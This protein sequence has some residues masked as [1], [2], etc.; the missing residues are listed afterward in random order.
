MFKYLYWDKKAPFLLSSPPFLPQASPLLLLADSGINGEA[1]GGAACGGHLAGNF[2][3]GGPTSHWTCSP[4]RTCAMRFSDLQPAVVRVGWVSPVEPEHEV[5]P[6]LPLGFESPRRR[7]AA[8]WSAAWSRAARMEE[9]GHRQT[10][11]A[12][13]RHQRARGGEGDRGEAPQRGGWWPQ[14]SRSD[15]VSSSDTNN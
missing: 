5:V 10:E 1:A 2:L 14:E 4:E 13:S 3:W 8:S 7:S 6:L 11:P 15:R 9:A 12:R